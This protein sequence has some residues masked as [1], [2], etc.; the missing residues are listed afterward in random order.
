M[1]P[2]PALLVGPLGFVDGA[3]AAGVE[4]AGVIACFLA[5]GG[6]SSSENDSQPCSCIVTLENQFTSPNNIG[7]RTIL[8]RVTYPYS[9][10]HPLLASSS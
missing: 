5:G 7:K 3:D 2:F 8:S 1:F 10:D 6:A 9:P 4:A